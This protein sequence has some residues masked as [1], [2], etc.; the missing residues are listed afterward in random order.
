MRSQAAS[1]LDLQEVATYSPGPMAREKKPKK[2]GVVRFRVTD[3]QE[4]LIQQAADKLDLDVT[5]FARMVVLREA[6]RV[7]SGELRLVEPPCQDSSPGPTG[8]R[9]P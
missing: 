9:K 7:L 8:K 2:E 4:G 3:D 6:R 5:A 1:V